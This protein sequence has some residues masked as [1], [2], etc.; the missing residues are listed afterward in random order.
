M[1]PAEA[2]GSLFKLSSTLVP[3]EWLL[4]L[5]SG[6]CLCL[7]KRIEPPTRPYGSCRRS[8]TRGRSHSGRLWLPGSCRSRHYRSVSCSPSSSGAGSHCGSDRSPSRGRTRSDQDQPGGS[9]YRESCR[10]YSRSRCSPSRGQPSTCH[11]SGSILCTSQR[12]GGLF[13]C[14]RGCQLR[15]AAACGPQHRTVCQEEMT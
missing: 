12:G 9:G 7:A 4:M 14:D 2:H 11:T 5:E 15:V 10:H 8:P 1:R 6:G 3:N 13:Q